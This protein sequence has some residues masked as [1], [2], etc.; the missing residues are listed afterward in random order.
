MRKILIVAVAL[1]ACK[2]PEPHGEYVG[3]DSTPPATANRTVAVAQPK[4]A[5]PPPVLTPLEEVQ[6]KKTFAEAL[7]FTRPK[8]R[9]TQ[10]EADTSALLFAAWMADK[11]AWADIAALPETSVAKVLKDSDEERGKRLCAGGT[12]VEIAKT[13]TD[14]AKLWS[15]GLSTMDGKI[16]RFVAVGSTGDLVERSNAR[17]CGVMTGRDSYSNSGGGTTHGVRVVGMFDLPENRKKAP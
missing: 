4:P 7:A 2:K 1:V 17:F 10:N 5:P 11:R 15:G 14:V 6:T 12:I 8:F 13:K 9:D 3:T 16:I